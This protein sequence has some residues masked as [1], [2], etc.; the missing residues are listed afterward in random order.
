MKKG[1]NK[2]KLYL[3]LGGFVLYAILVSVLVGNRDRFTRPVTE[4]SVVNETEVTPAPLIDPDRQ[5]DVFDNTVEYAAPGQGG[6]YVASEEVLVRDTDKEDILNRFALPSLERMS[7][8]DSAKMTKN[9]Q[10]LKRVEVLGIDTKE[11]FTPEYNWKKEYN[12]SLKVV[13]DSIAFENEVEFTGTKTSELNVFLKDLSEQTVIITAKELVLDETIHVPANVSLV[14]NDTTIKGDADL[15]Y[16]VQLEDVYN[17]SISDLTFSSGYR[18]GIYII[19]CRNVLVWNNRITNAG[20][21]ALCVMGKNEYIHVVNNTATENADGAFLFNGDISHCIIQGNSVY[22]N[23]GAG[24]MRAGIVLSGMPIQNLYDTNNPEVDVYLYEL[25]EAPHDNVIKDNIIQGNHSSGIYSFAGYRNYIID[26]TIEDNEKEGM[27]LDFGTVGTYVA[28]NTI[29]H[30]GNRDRQ[31]DDDLVRDYIAE[32]GR[33][34][35]GT[36]KAKLPGISLDNAAY[37]IVMSNSVSYN[38]GSGIKMVRSGYRNLLFGNIVD[39]N[40][41]GRNDFCFG[42]GIELGFASKP[43]LPVIGLDFTPDYENIIARN[44]INGSH[45]SG[46]FIAADVYCNDLIDNIVMDGTEFAIENHSTYF[47]SAVGNTVNRNNLD[48]DNY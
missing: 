43:D 40:N 31:T 22:Q 36:S 27:C 14:G 17:V 45:Y 6:R 2:K 41:V 4:E 37:N 24:N 7:E 20:T 18:F 25:T 9:L 48:F 39:D 10:A 13:E 32:I 11:L 5:F 12:T 1:T 47:T 28:K 26:N 30:N 15:M 38:Y 46:I 19:N 42:Y 3:C 8:E 35:D 16:A 29:C 33:M 34:E 21:K 23:M 44:T